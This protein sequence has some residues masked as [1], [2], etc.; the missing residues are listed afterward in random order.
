[1]ITW[2]GQGYVRSRESRTNRTLFRF[3]AST[4]YTLKSGTNVP[5][6]VPYIP[7]CCKLF[8]AY[9]TLST[10]I[11]V[12]VALRAPHT[13]IYLQYVP[14]GYDAGYIFAHSFLP[15]SFSKDKDVLQQYSSSMRIFTSHL[16]IALTRPYAW[17][18]TSAFL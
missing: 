1:M 12:L 7:V 10:G 2:Y 17:S 3:Q 4:I 5:L 15:S 16:R 14:A 11:P 18:T 13:S 9:E 6:A 8:R